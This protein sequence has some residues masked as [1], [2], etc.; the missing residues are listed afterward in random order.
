MVVAGKNERRR[1]SP[2]PM[3]ST[4]AGR[5]NAGT[6][7]RLLGILLALFLGCALPCI[8]QS[9]E[10]TGIQTVLVLAF[11]NESKAPGL[12]WIGE[13]FPEVLGQ[14]LAAARL[15]VISR[16]DREYAFD[17]FGIPSNLRPSRATLYRIAEQMDADFVV[18][19]KYGYDG[20]TFSCT[21]EVLDMKQLRLS[22]DMSSDGPLP[23]L[24]EVQSGLAWQVLQKV[25]PGSVGG[26]EEFVRSGEPIRLDAFEN[27]I[28]GIVATS[29]QDRIRYLREALRLKPQYTRAMLALGR[30]YFNVREYQSAASWFARIPKTNPSAGEANFYLGLASFYSGDFDKADAAFR[31]VITRLPLTE[32]YNNLGVVASRRGRRNNI[33]YFQKAV[34]QDPN[35]PD[36]RFNL[37]VA[38]YRSG[39]TAGA[40]RQIREALSRRPGDSEA[41]DF[42]NT[43]SN[44]ASAAMNQAAGAQTTP[45]HIP[46]ERIKS[47]YDENSY[48]QLAIEVQ[49]ATELALANTDPKTHASFHVKQ[50]EDMLQKGFVTDA[51]R[52][53]RE[54]VM[55]DPT[56][57]MA[58]AGLARIAETNGDAVTARREAETSLRLQQ[59][60]DAFLVLGRLD[61]KDNQIDSAQ[62][63]ADKALWLEPTNTAALSLKREIAAK[64]V[65]Q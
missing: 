23:N 37:G 60:A 2:Y 16:E 63:N 48:R 5:Y 36:Y 35:D 40:I 45:S 10:H 41:R 34:Q 54:A 49:N 26:R 57:A 8:A 39:D 7:K 11:E 38:L 12:E 1:S 30:T 21:A 52:E 47:N 4:L 43:M 62:Q 25:A 24:I 61:L 29:R 22:G 19:G 53:F 17:H 15:F 6:L 32:V 50:G 20:Q 56:N 51:D 14:R 31:F 9:A 33:E 13:A 64:H 55:R 44:V 46:L 18:F 65:K 59:N 28:R 42:L 58:H 27:Y 3:I